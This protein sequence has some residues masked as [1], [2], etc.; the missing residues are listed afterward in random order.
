LVLLYTSGTTGK[1]KGVML[2]HANL[3]NFSTWFKHQY[4]LTERDNVA[5]YA[6]YG[7]DA[8]LMDLYPTLLSGAS[9][10]I[11]PE[12][13]RLD[14]PA[15]NQY[16][17][18]HQVT[19]AFMTTQL[20]RQFAESMDNHSLRTLTTGGETLVP[21]EPPEN[22]LFY[23]AYGPTECTIFST[24]YQ[25]DRLYDRVPLGKPLT[26]TAIYIIDKHGRLS[27]IGA[28]G[29]LCIAGRQVAKGYLNRPDLTEEKF[30]TNP[31][32]N[33]PDYARMYR[34]GDI[35]RYLPSG[36]IDFIGRRDFQVKIRGFRVE[37][38]EIE[39]RI[40][41]YPGITDAAVVAKDAP[42]GG[43]CAV[44]YI[45]ANT[46]VDTSVLNAFI[47]EALP[48]YMVPAATMQLEKIPLNPNGK[49]DRNKLPMPVYAGAE[50]E[51]E[52]DT[53]L[54]TELE[55][56]IKEVVKGILGHDQFGL[57][58]DLFRN[59][60][61]SLSAIKLAAKL[62][63]RLGVAPLVRELM[64]EPTVVGIENA[65]VRKL[66]ELAQN[67]AIAP[68]VVSSPKA[69]R[70]DYPLSQN[71]LGVFFDCLKRP[72]T[73]AYNIPLQINF[74]PGVDAKKLVEAVN[75]VIDAHPAV[76]SHLSMRGEEILQVPDFSPADI[77]LEE[78]SSL[79]L[80]TIALGFV[81][82]FALFEGPLY[83]GRVVK[84]PE[85]VT[86]FADFH[87]LA[88]DGGSLDA[89]LRQLCQTYDTGKFPETEGEKTTLFEWALQ[90]RH[91]EGSATW[92]QDKAYF[93]R[94]LKGFEGASEIA[95]DLPHSDQAGKMAEVVR[96]VAP[97]KLEKYCKLN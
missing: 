92:L 49:V 8:C 88:F 22:F 58:T 4:E 45:V 71:Q 85:G 10:H 84:T 23:N 70:E 11:I 40:R 68:V 41:M 19:V 27:P 75:L 63:D 94:E 67:Q 30:V 83:R 7:F 65:L 6:S 17:N 61:T 28:A 62:Q 80:S 89:F 52:D 31:F 72:D 64:R 57:T 39:G 78:T 93:D 21:V 47:E 36:D 43:K 29:E 18:E 20:G 69:P 2:T 97:L 46:P 77:P 66:L 38:T 24:L 9:V 90:E 74:S 95:P 16:F 86:L 26:N 59:G 13:M 82:P 25:V 44:A 35:A 60:L 73:L 1:P 51:K 50:T 42:A 54:A 32:R 48:P 96:T 81:K 56:T 91:Q 76:K 79:E 37:L 87:H 12:E 34:T 53:R 33:D 55:A 15:L 3:V 5:A 14:L